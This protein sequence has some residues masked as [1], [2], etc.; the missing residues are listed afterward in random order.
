MHGDDEL[1]ARTG[2][3]FACLRAEFACAAR[4]PDTWLR[5]R[6]RDGAKA[7][8]GPGSPARITVRKLLSPVALAS[9]EPA[10]YS[11]PSAAA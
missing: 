2:Q 1:E 10:R 6:S 4:D 5:T 7:P 3:L 11:A 8:F 9:E